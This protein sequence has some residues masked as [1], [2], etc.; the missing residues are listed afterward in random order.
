[1]NTCLVPRHASNANYKGWHYSYDCVAALPLTTPSQPVQ[2]DRSRYNA[3]PDM[4]MGSMLKERPSC[5]TTA[6]GYFTTA[7]SHAK[8]CF[9]H[10]PKQLSW[11]TDEPRCSMQRCSKATCPQCLDV[12]RASRCALLV[13]VHCTT[14]HVRAPCKTQ[15]S[16]LD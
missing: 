1:M 2:Q 16:C 8:P 6:S 13:G 15:C 14:H 9:T 3:N 7:A 11:K 4:S 10:H 5:Q 12:C